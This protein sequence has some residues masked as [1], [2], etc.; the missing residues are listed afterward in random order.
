[1]GEEAM[2]K[3]KKMVAAAVALGVLAIG[4]I[5]VA[6]EFDLPGF[7]TAEEEIPVLQPESGQQVAVLQIGLQ[8]EEDGSV[9]AEL[10]SQRVIDSFAPKSF[11]RAGGDWEVRVVGET[12]VAFRIPNPLNAEVENPDDPEVPFETVQ[13]ESLEWTLVV[14]LYDEGQS[15]GAETIEITDLL[16]GTTILSTSIESG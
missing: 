6:Q 2:S 16:T 9:S 10:I 15:L 11:S 4:T 14:P 3:R 1:M 8:S 7:V 13:L 5:V 12:T